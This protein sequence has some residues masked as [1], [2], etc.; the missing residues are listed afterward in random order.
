MINLNPRE[1]A[2]LILQKPIHEEY[3]RIFQCPVEFNTQ[4]FRLY[5]DP[6]ILGYRSPY[7]EPELLSMHVQSADQHMELLEKRD[8]N[9]SR[10]VVRW[11]P[12]LRIW[13]HYA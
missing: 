1:F 13:G 10:S 11:A 4:Q 7:A 9:L 6:Q 3:Q 8:L 2:L 5:F 12:Y